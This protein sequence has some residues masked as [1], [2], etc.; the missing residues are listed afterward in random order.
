MKKYHRKKVF[1][2]PDWKIDG[3]FEDHPDADS[4]KYPSLGHQTATSMLAMA[5]KIRRL[6]SL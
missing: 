3:K 1:S 6:K 4:D 2:V 5:E